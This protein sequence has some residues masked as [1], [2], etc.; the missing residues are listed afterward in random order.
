MPLDV[1]WL[2]VISTNSCKSKWN[3]NKLIISLFQV[4]KDAVDKCMENIKRRYSGDPIFYVCKP[5]GGAKEVL[6]ILN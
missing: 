3:S 1:K 5:A 2:D 6:L 4:K